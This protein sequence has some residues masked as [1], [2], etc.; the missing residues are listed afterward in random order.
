MKKILLFVCG[1]A[2]FLMS[3][4]PA[5]KPTVYN[6]DATKSTFKWTGKKVT[7]SHWGYVKFSN[8]QVTTEGDNIVGGTFT[9]DMTSMDVQDIKGEYAGKLLGHLKSDDF[10]GVDK[11]GTSTLTIK[12]ATAKGNNSYDIVADLTIKGITSEV[13]FPATITKDAKSLTAQAAFKV[14]RTKYDIKYRSGSFFSD[15]GDK[16]I[17]D[18]FE[19]EVNLAAVAA[20]PAPTVKKTAKKSNTKKNAKAATTSK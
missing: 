15:L 1:A 9:V 4:T 8:G 13:T 20:A 16:A 3:F 11:F 10:F 6:V 5:P 17:S 7:G 14:N 19:V 2:L 12:K 18:D